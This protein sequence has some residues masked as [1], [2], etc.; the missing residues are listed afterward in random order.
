MEQESLRFAVS[1]DALQNRDPILAVI[2]GS[3]VNNDGQRKVGYLAPSVDGH[4]DVVKEALAVAGLS[5]RDL[6]L[7]EAHGTGTSVGDPIEVAALTQAFRV[8]TSDLGFCHLV[9]T[10]PNIG[11]LDTAAGVAS[12]IKV[13]QAMRHRI[14]P[15][16]ANH[17]APSPLLDIERTPFLISADPLPWPDDAPRRAGVSSLG[18]GGTNA[19]VVVEEAP[20]PPPTPAARPEQLLAL[21][22]VDGA[23]LDL[24]ARR[25]A[26][27]L[28]AEPG[29][30]LADVA[31]TL[32][33]GRRA[34]PHRRVVAATD[35]A[36][37][38]EVLRHGDRNRVASA[39]ASNDA[40]RVAFLFPGGGAHYPGMAAALDDRFDVFHEVMEDG[41][42]RLRERHGL[43]LAPLLRA[44]ASSQA[45]RKTTAS[46]PA[47]FLTSVA[48]AR[49]W[50][51]WGVTPSA[52][53]GHSLGEYTAAHLAGVLTLDGALD[54]IVARATLIDTVSGVGAAM[55]AVP[56]PVDEVQPL[57]PPS[58][59]VAT[60]N[61]D[62]ECVIAGPLEDIEILA[63]QVSTDEIQ[64]TLLPINAA[65]HSSLLDPILPDFLEHVRR[66]ELLP[67]QIPYLSNLSGTWITPEQATDPQYW[68]DHLR[69][70]VRFS[71]C[72]R[73]ALADG[74]LVMLEMGPGHSL[75]SYARRQEVKPLAAIPVLRHPNQEVDDTAAVL[76][77]AGRAW[78][79]GIDLDVDRFAGLNR[80]LLRLPGYPFRREHHWIEPGEGRVA[81]ATAPARSAASAEARRITNLTDAFW[82]PTWSEQARTA[83]T[84]RPAGTWLVVAPSGDAL[85]HRAGPSADLARRRR[86]AD[87]H[88][89]RSSP[90]R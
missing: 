13:I 66:I 3:A 51:A 9:S 43:D 54:L 40:H 48:L 77:A 82:A 55:L 46:L 53:V 17:T 85:G 14:L 41:L 68:V 70:T 79:V 67:P 12:L 18:V 81:A 1:P 6:Q 21:S 74:P 26:D 76:L 50:M 61:A 5:A 75:S 34:M 8:S 36:N 86:G 7:L 83:P 80:R 32:A 4:A 49:Q 47:V 10:K 56:L 24:T 23:T 25:L 2:K 64:P 87:R 42:R 44:D 72:L 22:A 45:L 63:K 37:A 52:F 30:N 11:H 33:V 69:R 39:V 28:E 35:T 71:D 73:A 20:L 84:T 57:L 19:H 31:H 16:L 58:L 65:G 78:A 88:V 29:I 59:S 60:I 90:H 15:P 89:R 62:D 27:A 38:I